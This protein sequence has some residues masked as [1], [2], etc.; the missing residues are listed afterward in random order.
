MIRNY[1]T[2][3][4]S[5]KRPQKPVDLYSKYKVPLK[6]RYPGAGPVYISSV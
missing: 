5:G 4:F 6:P 3:P 2:S 1:Q